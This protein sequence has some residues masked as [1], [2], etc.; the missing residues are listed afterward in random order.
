MNRNSIVAIFGAG[1]L[2]GAEIVKVL[3]AKNFANI[4]ESKHKDLDL[5]DQSS[6]RSFFEEHKPEYVFFCATRSIT[7]FES[8][9]EIDAVELYSNLMMQMN[10]MEA[11]RVHGTK[12]AV[13]L[14]SAMLYPWNNE[15]EDEPLKEKFL[16]DFRIT[17]Y[18]DPMRSSVLSKYVCMKLCQ[19]YYRQY[20]SKFIYVIPTHIYGN[21]AGRKNLYFLEH[22]VMDLCDAKMSDSASVFLDVF[23]EGKAPK[24]ILH[25]YDCANAI[26]TVMEK[27]ED[28]SEP[29]N[30]GS[31]VSESW[32]SVVEKICRILDFHGE[33]L[34][35]SERKERMENRICNLDKL[36]SLGWTQKID[37]DTGLKS[38][39]DEYM[40]MKR[41]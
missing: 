40:N 15:H 5:I 31:I 1:G 38:L 11:A 9:D 14:G 22:M 37:M 32:G 17:Q 36:L 25:V 28:F 4:V 20:G 19:Y 29:I 26:C 34:F 16:E 24:Q 2:I 10:V 3:K 30:I 27:Y 6:V 18:R 7:N 41:G 13:F 8:G 33:V 23:G 21:L 12:K 35:N 39:C